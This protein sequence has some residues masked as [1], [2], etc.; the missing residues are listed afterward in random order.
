MEATAADTAADSEETQ[1]AATKKMRQKSQRAREGGN[2][3]LLAIS[4]S[5]S[6]DI[7]Y[8]TGYMWRPR[9]WENVGYDAMKNSAD[10]QYGSSQ[11]VTVKGVNSIGD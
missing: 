3:F 2:Q 9:N 11:S 10:I 4:N 8:N 6:M 1:K 7:H 5:P